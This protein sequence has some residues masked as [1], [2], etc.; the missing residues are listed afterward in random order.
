[1]E[2]RRII[3]GFLTR[4][5]DALARARDRYGDYLKNLAMRILNDRED[6]EECVSDALYKAWRNIPPE[7][8]VYLGAWLGKVTRRLA[9]DRLKARDAARR[10]GGERPLPWDDLP[11]TET[12]SRPDGP[13]ETVLAEGLKASV[14]AFVSGLP[15]E[16]KDV[17]LRRFWYLDS[18]AEIAVRHGCSEGRITMMLRRMKEKLRR[19]LK[20]EGW[21]E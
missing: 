3:E 10:G 19:Q 6:A 4:D 2:D 16:Q 13:E 11:E 1:M 9:I 14:A 21:I 7:E 18:V 12:A 20:E 5:E 8:P 15:A 17:F